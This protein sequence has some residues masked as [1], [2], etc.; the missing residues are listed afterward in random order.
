MN[1]IA[2]IIKPVAEE[3]GK[4][5]KTATDQV[6]GQSKD[7]TREFVKSLYGPSQTKSE[8]P[9]RQ[10]FA[11][12]EETKEQK[13]AKLRHELHAN[14]YQNLVNR[15]KAPKERPA[16]KVEKEKQEEMI[17]LQKKEAKKPSQLVQKAQQRVEKYPGASG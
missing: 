4:F 12:Q 17:D 3:L 2:T 9:L 11:G 7:E 6:A 1:K 10:G 16:E 13:L 5:A 15:P 8:T 14:Y